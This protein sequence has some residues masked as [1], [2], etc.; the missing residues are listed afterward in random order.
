MSC[1]IK[2]KLGY[3]CG[4]P[5]K[6]FNTCGIHK[7]YAD[8]ISINTEEEKRIFEEFTSAY[9]Q[10]MYDARNAS[11]RVERQGMNILNIQRAYPQGLFSTPDLNKL[12]ADEQDFVRAINRGTQLIQEYKLRLNDYVIPNAASVIGNYILG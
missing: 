7:H 1:Q 4:K 12:T 6:H 3:I 9:S 8:N 11:D 10:A 2:T 5:I